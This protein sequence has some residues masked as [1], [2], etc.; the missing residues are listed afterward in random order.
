MIHNNSKFEH[1]LILWQQERIIVNWFHQFHYKRKQC[2]K[3]L[4]TFSQSQL[5]IEVNHIKMT[6]LPYG[7]VK[8][9][10]ELWLCFF[11]KSSYIP[12]RGTFAPLPHVYSEITPWRGN[13]R[14]SKP[15]NSPGCQLACYTVVYQKQDLHYVIAGD[16]ESKVSGNYRR[17][18]R[19]REKVPYRSR[20]ARVW[21]FPLA[22]SKCRAC[23]QANCHLVYHSA[24]LNSA[25]TVVY[26]SELVVYSSF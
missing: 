24:Q 19:G 5:V 9:E 4:G 18:A 21:P 25:T 20:L 17:E 13:W 14:V 1:L 15:V 3:H 10:T 7:V 8:S 26:D 11:T 6:S 22:T 12:L 16:E 23:F 2:L